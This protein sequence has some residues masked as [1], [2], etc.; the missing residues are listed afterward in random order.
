MIRCRPQLDATTPT[1]PCRTACAAWWPAQPK[2]VASRTETSPTPY[3]AARSTARSIASRAT[4]SPS[5]RCASS[6][7][8]APRSAST[9]GSAAGSARPA[10]S[11]GR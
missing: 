10:A 4:H 7:T 9:S 2:W 5:P 8:A 3:A 6:S 11:S 1:I